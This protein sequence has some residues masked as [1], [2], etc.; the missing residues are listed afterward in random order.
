MH[1]TIGDGGN[2]EKMVAEYADEPGN[3]PEP[4]TT[5]D[6]EPSATPDSIMGCFYAYTFTS[7]LAKWNFYW[8]RQSEY[9]AYRESSFMHEILEVKFV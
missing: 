2:Q 5:P 9:S 7:G 6:S 8:D 1:I 3:Y 4:S